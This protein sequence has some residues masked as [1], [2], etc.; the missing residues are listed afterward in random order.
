MRP[1]RSLLLFIL[2]VFVGGA[3]LAPQLYFLLQKVAPTSHLLSAGFHRYINRS[4]ICLALIGIWP[5]LKSLGATSWKELGL[6]K[7]IGQLKN[8]AAGF[9]LGFGSL[10]CLALIVL[11]SHGRILNHDLS[12]NVLG[13]KVGE[14][15][16]AALSVSIIEEILFRG[17]IFGA[18]RR[19]WNW[20]TALLISSMIYAIVHF[21]QKNDISGPITWYSGFNQLLHML[22]GFINLQQVIPG[23]FNLTLAGIILGVA[24]QKT[25][26]LYLSMGL[27]AGWI[28]WLKFYG[29]LTQPLPG[30]NVWFWGSENPTTGWLALIVLLGAFLVLQQLLPQ[31]R[32]KNPA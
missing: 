22:S 27:H 6:V 21:F 7:P 2:F 13:K 8:W 15:V 23:F 19:I 3:L 14:A 18:L 32:P 9:V 12:S 4:L 17:A 29:T 31:K 30:S 5:L 28:F 10:A 16:I 11:L 25:G 20:R 1:L 26:N 24:Y